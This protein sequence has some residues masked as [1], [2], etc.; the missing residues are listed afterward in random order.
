MDSDTIELPITGMSCVGCA[1]SIEKTLSSKAGVLHSAVNFAQ[2]NVVVTIDPSQI[3]RR[4]IIETI[5]N[6]G[7]EVVEA[8]E[9][10]STE[11]T[12]AL[13]HQ[14]ELERQ[15]RRLCVGLVLTIP[16]FVFSMARDFGFLGHWSHHV[17]FN[18]I[19]FALATPVQL[20]VGW[21]YYTSG[22]KSLR[23][24]MAN[25]D[26]LVSIGSLAAFL[27]SVVVTVAT[28]FS[29]SRWGEHV[30]FET[31]ATI[32][33]LILLGRL[34]ESRANARTGAAIKKLLGMQAKSARVMRNGHEM[35]IPI[36]RVRPGDLVVVRPGEKIPVDG[37]VTAGQSAV[38]ESF[39]TG[40]SLPI[41][42]SVDMDVIGATINREGLLTIR[43][44]KLGRESALAQ[45]IKQVEHAQST[46]APVQHLADQI[47][48]IF[49]PIVILVALIA[50]CVWNFIVGDFTQALLR[51][52]SVLIISCPCAM[53]LATPLAVMVGMGRGAERGILFKSSKAIQTLAAAN[54][55]VL[56]KT[57]TVSEGKLSVTDVIPCSPFD[58]DELVRIA[59]SVERGSEHPIAS[60]IVA[61][62]QSKGISL[63]E[64][65]DFIARPG[66]GVT[67][68]L[69]HEPI[70]I[71]NRRW[72]NE[73][74]I[75]THEMSDRASELERQ[76]KTVMWIAKNKQVVGIVA[77]AD[78]LKP[79]SAVAIG[80]M[81]EMGLALTMITGD[82][83]HTADAI[84][85]TLGIEN[86]LA[87]TLP[88]DKASQVAK[89]Q[90]AQQVVVMVGDGIN[91]A[92]ALA[93]ADVGIAIGT[94]TD[95]AI[96][97]ADVTLLRG[98]LMSVPE[99]IRL[100]RATMRNI[101]Q[102]LFWAFAYNVLLIPVAAGAL[103]GF[104]FVPSFLRELHPILAAFAMIASDLVIVTNALRLQSVKLA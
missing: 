64:A 42:K 97:S 71:G 3:D 53:G 79:T 72:M 59:A 2:S 7:F 87:E 70:V 34:I 4:Q 49:V 62:A 31:S 91:D 25:M 83:Q 39:I 10:K 22:L 90:S 20:Y 41:E 84:A 27:Y 80:K 35:E 33:T 74:E 55:I 68:R 94:G 86:V 43:A 61:H 47:S 56:D 51:T 52:I 13:A 5:R 21:D 76:A 58:S 69:D 65:H 40:E 17:I 57:G 85:A 88:A 93:A 60:A 18:W 11:E 44:T 104:A 12:A 16:L 54:Q 45:I 66:H 23:R 6:T 73:N 32:I 77:V 24:G 81:K 67:A 14:L 1:K 100:S 8:G 38:D 37:V 103:A 19:M 82:N 75:S 63:G 36:E 99:A 46:K 101:K 9:G 92:P 50:F 15:W 48:G 26:V 28:T 95:I 78:T 30:Y 96:E 98:D 102:N 29:I 89:L